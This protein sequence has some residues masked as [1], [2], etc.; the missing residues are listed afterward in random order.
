MNN[1]YLRVNSKNDDED[2][3]VGEYIHE[4][5]EETANKQ[6]KK[7]TLLSLLSF[8]R[9]TNVTYTAKTLQTPNIKGVFTVLFIHLAIAFALCF[10]SAL[11]SNIVLLIFTSAVASLIFPVFIT[12]FA[13]K[14]DTTDGVSLIEISIGFIVGTCVY[15]IFSVFEPIFIQFIYFDWIQYIVSVII[16]DVFLF[17]VANVFVKLARKDNMFDAIL[18]TVT[19]YAGYMFISSFSALISNMFLSVQLYNGTETVSTGAI[20]LGKES[21]KNIFTSFNET[22]LIQVTFLS[23]VTSSNAI[24]NGGVI[25]LNVSPIKDEKYK[26]WSLYLLF[27][28]TVVLHIAAVFPSSIRLF[29]LILKGLSIIF[30][31]ILAITILNYYLSKAKFKE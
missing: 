3:V 4:I 9:K 1:D 27:L 6:E 20:I 8:S 24:V 18:L 21:F 29:E 13:Y 15:L 7:V 25:G 5:K 19:V 10:F 22:L 28:L 17:V 11:T 12:T 26:E 31:V 23:V 16:R 30:S 2:I 14:L